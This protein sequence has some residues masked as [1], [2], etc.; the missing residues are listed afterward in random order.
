VG[1]GGVFTVTYAVPD[2][3][4]S[5]VDVA[6]T[7]A[8]PVAVGV[9]TS[10]LLTLPIL[11]GLTDQVTALLKFPVPVTVGVQVEVWVV[12]MDEGEQTTATEVIVTGTAVTV[13]VADPDFV[14]F[15]VEV[16]VMVAE[17]ELGDVA[18]AV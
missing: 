1:D 7:V 4:V 2:R 18:G 12:R 8:V 5:C 16:A 11:D 9:K 10:A 15:C 3:V 14:A 6:C 13:T 17:P